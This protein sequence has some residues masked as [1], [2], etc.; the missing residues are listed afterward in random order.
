MEGCEKQV[1]AG[2]QCMVG[3]FGHFAANILLLFF[4]DLISACQAARYLAHNCL[5]S[6]VAVPFCA[7]SEMRINDE[8]SARPVYST[9]LP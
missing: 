6:T 9:V 7:E 1:W 5:I 4:G 2:K 3:D 8:V